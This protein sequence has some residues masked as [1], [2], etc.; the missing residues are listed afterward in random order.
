MARGP[1]PKNTRSRRDDNARRQA[2]MV[3]L[4]DTG[5]LAGPELPAG[6]LPDGQD[7]HPQTRALWQELRR[8]PLTCHEPALGWSY[9]IDTAVLHHLAW[10][11]GRWDLASELRLRLAKFG[12]TPEDRQRLRIRVVQPA[13]QRP[14]PVTPAGVA[15]ITA[16]RARLT[17]QSD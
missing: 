7:W 10:Q 9:L 4:Q 11:H 3:D 12:V 2:E 6:V 13:D 8:S 16:R 17:E 5:E 15:S 1:L 14:E